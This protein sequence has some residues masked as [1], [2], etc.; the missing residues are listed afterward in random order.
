MRM[1]ILPS[2]IAA[3]AIMVGASGCSSGKDPLDTAAAPVNGG[4]DKMPAKI[5]GK[6]GYIAPPPNKGG[7]MGDR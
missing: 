3:L 5:P 7:G 6:V 2:I 1:P 4:T